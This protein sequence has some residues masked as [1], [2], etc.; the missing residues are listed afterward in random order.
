MMPAYANYSFEE[1]RLAYLEEAV[2]NEKLK[3]M[4]RI[5]GR[6]EQQCNPCIRVLESLVFKKFVN[7]KYFAVAFSYNSLC[8]VFMS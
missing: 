4:Q 8:Y 2:L 7:K 3:V 1:L 5:D 6:Y